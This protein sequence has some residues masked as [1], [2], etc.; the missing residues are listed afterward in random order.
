M[1]AILQNIR[2]K[3]NIKYLSFQLRQIIFNGFFFF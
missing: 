3:M 2:E 1:H